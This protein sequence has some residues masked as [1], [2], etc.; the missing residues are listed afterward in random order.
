MWMVA[1]GLEWWFVGL[2]VLVLWLQEGIFKTYQAR[3]GERLLLAV[4][5]MAVGE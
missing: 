5:V 2:V 3:L 4:A 1:F